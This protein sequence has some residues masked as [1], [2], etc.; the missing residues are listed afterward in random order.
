MI[1]DGLRKYKKSDLSE[2]ARLI[3]SVSSL[4]PIGWHADCI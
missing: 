1:Y 3:A 4:T 2:I